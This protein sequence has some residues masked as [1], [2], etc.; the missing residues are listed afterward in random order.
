MMLTMMMM[1]TMMTKHSTI[2]QGLCYIG[3]M[4]SQ[5]STVN[6]VNK[7]PGFAISIDT[8]MKLFKG[9]SNMT[10]CMKQRLIKDGFKFYVVC[11]AASG[12]LLLFLIPGRSMWQEE[13]KED[14][15]TQICGVVVWAILHLPNRTKNQYVVVMDNY[16]T[17]I[18]TMIST[19][20]CGVATMKTA[21]TR[22]GW[23][24][25][26]MGKQLIQDVQYNSL[27][28]TKK[29]ITIR[30]VTIESFDRLIT[31]LWWW[32]QIFIPVYIKWCKCS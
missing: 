16:F 2:K 27:W 8:K 20:K 6:T 3:Q 7:Y 13:K 9:W 28:Y 15:D 1:M 19:L 10:N 18:K 4:N 12:W 26:D 22:S 17:L 24:S 14:D 30:L 32:F 25:K 31:I 21:S 29:N 11:C 5:E 23:P